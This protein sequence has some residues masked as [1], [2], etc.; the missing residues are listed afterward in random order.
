MRVLIA[1]LLVLS[2]SGQSQSFVRR[3]VDLND[4]GNFEIAH[5]SEYF[6]AALLDGY[7]R[8]KIK[9]YRFDYIMDTTGKNARFP[10]A[11][12]V[13]PLAEFMSGFAV[14][15]EF[16]TDEPWDAQRTY[17]V[18]ATAL[19]KG[20]PYTGVRENL[21]KPPDV[22]SEDWK[23][24]DYY[25]VFNTPEL[26]SIFSL[27]CW[28]DNGRMIPQMLSVCF[29]RSPIDPLKCPSLN[30]Y[31]EDVVAY[32]RQE[33]KYFYTT[34]KLGYTGSPQLLP[35][36]YAYEA[37][38]RFIHGKLT[39]QKLKP[40]ANE[41]IDQ[42]QFQK[43]LTDPISGQYDT[44]PLPV[45]DM[46]SNDLLIQRWDHEGEQRVTRPVVELAWKSVEAI[47]KEE[48]P[49]VKILDGLDMIE[50]GAFAV[51]REETLADL[52][53]TPRLTKPLTVATP[54]KLYFIDERK[55]VPGENPAMSQAI[56]RVWA[57]AGQAC[58]DGKILS[59]AQREVMYRCDQLLPELMVSLNKREWLLNKGY[60][61]YS[62]E[63]HY[64]VDST[65]L[66]RP[67]SRLH[68]QYK[69]AIGKNSFRPIKV[70]FEI[71]PTPLLIA[72]YYFTW[73]D[74]VKTTSRCEE[75]RPFIR[76]LKK[77]DLAFEKSEAVT[78]LMRGK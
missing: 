13:T 19:H 66:T 12:D 27:L 39:S 56:Q 64:T 7:L 20:L 34:S 18:E 71:R 42:S 51:Y 61:F 9:A 3:W 63:T 14:G 52:K 23:P 28:N 21:N 36:S 5:G 11:Q 58:R 72:T 73:D 45:Q 54:R 4:E 2:F 53:L 38:L 40:A 43:L 32:L 62:E 76:A 47:L 78:E 41:I 29:R 75:C 15:E 1:L 10:G 25:L 33:E 26:L 70:A 30:F 55:V 8:G 74:F 35:D 16:F 49:G 69:R 6:G 65:H 44:Y 68:V 59:S 50:A 67:V 22:S 17:A 37:L 60:N 48:N 46:T 31:Y 57:I 77:G 24:Q